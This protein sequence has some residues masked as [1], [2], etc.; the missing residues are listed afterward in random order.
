MPMATS[1]PMRTTPWTETP[2]SP[3]PGSWGTSRS[4]T[5]CQA[6]A[7]AS[8]RSTDHR[9]RV[10]TS[11]FN[12]PEQEQ[13]HPQQQEHERR[14]VHAPGVL[15]GEHRIGGAVVGRVV[16]AE[17]ERHDEPDADAE[18]EREHEARQREVGTDH[19]AGVDQ[20]QDVGRRGEE[21]ERD[22]RAE[23]RALGEDPGKQRNDRARADG[24]QRPGGG[25]RGVGG[26]PGRVAAE[27][28]GDGLLRDQRR[29]RPGDEERRQQAEQHVR[30]EVG[31]EVPQAA[32]EQG[33]AERDHGI[34]GSAHA[35]LARRARR[36]ADQVDIGAHGN[37]VTPSLHGALRRRLIPV[38]AVPNPVPGRP[39]RT[40]PG[41]AGGGF[42]KRARGVV[43]SALR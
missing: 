1:S 16:A 42:G 4:R 14:P 25:S 35:A 11:S 13:R 21:Q 39:L 24:E 10:S 9:A 18:H 34:Q 27:E 6:S 32:L 15:R 41:A 17:D 12:V 38:N 22:G 40:T 8:G 7:P 28:A 33:R 19:A 37:N 26:R 30:G 2:S 29:H 5:C 36:I 23:A 3:R 20:R 31:G 43:C